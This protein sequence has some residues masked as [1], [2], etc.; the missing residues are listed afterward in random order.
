MSDFQ[1]ILPGAVGLPRGSNLSGVRVAEGAEAEGRHCVAQTR[2]TS[3]PPPS[4]PPADRY[5]PAR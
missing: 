3:P 4:S 5:A 2:R 1:Y